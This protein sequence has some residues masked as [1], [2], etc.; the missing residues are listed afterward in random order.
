MELAVGDQT[1]KRCDGDYSSKKATEKMEKFNL[2]WHC[3]AEH[4]RKFKNISLEKF[5]ETK[6]KVSHFRI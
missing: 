3:L 4:S 2:C 6:R 5:A 1:C